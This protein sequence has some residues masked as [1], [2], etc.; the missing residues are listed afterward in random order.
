[1]AENIMVVTIQLTGTAELDRFFR[2]YPNAL[3]ASIRE[4]GVFA[5]QVITKATPRKTGTARRSWSKMDDSA[6][7]TIV[8]AMPYANYLEYGTGLYGPYA[9]PI[10]AKSGKWLTFPI[11]AGNKIKSFVR[12]VSVKG[13]K[14]VGMIK[15]NRLAIADFFRNSAV[16]KIRAAWGATSRGR[17]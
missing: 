11:I 13:I 14:A 5:K 7:T 12:V 8:N 2:T 10:T 1:V 9:R 4:T 6:G 15:N 3:T 17:R 16:A